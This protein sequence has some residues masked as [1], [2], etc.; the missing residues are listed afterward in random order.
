MSAIVTYIR[1]EAAR[2]EALSDEEIMGPQVD[3]RGLPF[4]TVKLADIE[5]L[6][7]GQVQD[8]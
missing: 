8:A 2:L 4:P 7:F 3:G 1:R 5:K 6:Q